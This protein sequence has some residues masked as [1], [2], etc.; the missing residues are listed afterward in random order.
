MNIKI[1]YQWLLEYLETDADPYELQKYLSLCGPGVERVEK[2]KT[3]DGR[4]DY[5][6]DIEVTTNRVDMASVFG[7]AQEAQAILPRFGKKAVLKQNP[8]Q[9]L[10]FQWKHQFTGTELPLTVTVRNAT[11][12]SRLVTV[13][14][15]DVV[16]GPSPD[17]IR[18]RL[19]FCG[20]RS[21]NN[22]I[23]ISNYL[24]I[25]LGQPC[26][27]FDYDQIKGHEMV[28]RESAKGETIITLDKESVVLP[29][30]DI[31][32]ADGEGNLIDQPGIMGGFNSSVQKTTKRIVLFVPVFNGALVRR[33]AML[34]GKRSNAVAYFEKNID[35][36]RAESATV[37]ALSLLMKHGGAQQASAIQD[38]RPQK[39]V[40]Q[41]IDVSHP[42]ITSRIGIEI[43][44]KECATILNNLGFKT[45]YNAK[46]KILHS[47]VPE[48]R[49]RDISIP[50]DIVEEIA[51]IYGYHNLP[52]TISP[53]VYVPQPREF[54]QLFETQKI[55][56]LHLKHLGLHESMNYSMISQELIGRMSLAVDHHLKVAN[57]ISEELQYMRTSLLP[58]L[59]E[60]LRQNQGKRDLLRFFEIAKVYYPQEGELPKEIYKVAVATNTSFA[61]LKGIVESLL[62]E[63][64]IE[65]YQLAKAKIH[66]FSADEVVDF[67]QGDR[68]FGSIG[69]LSTQ[70]QHANSL[71]TPAYLAS[72]DLLSLI[73]LSAPTG[74]YTPV[75]Q[76][77]TVKLDLNISTDHAFQDIERS[78]RT[79]SKLLTHLEYSGTY[80]DRHTIRFY[81]SSRDKNLTEAEAQRELALIQTALTKKKTS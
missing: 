23:D 41:T 50:E 54:R 55:I 43:S 49:K 28:V 72:F 65:S 78:A 60:N 20:E 75:S 33:T 69:K 45:T 24:R 81:F 39:P 32:I 77:A 30:K 61:D 16:I 31:V 76:Y 68:V 38:Y 70:L 3:K 79:A 66:I 42:F 56:K 40:T 2:V 71:K 57:A 10:R 62:R 53:M 48:S 13:A 37:C 46:K 58:S 80:G 35:D 47:I 73:E 19:E 74:T 22:V 7:I 8:L 64:H 18:E 52:N 36:D 34:T 9:E 67:V 26:H 1:T 5:V 11:F 25:A 6:F 15:S 17:L 44:P 51:R 29:G 63:L 59:V 4:T 14:L 27:I 12:A 21:L